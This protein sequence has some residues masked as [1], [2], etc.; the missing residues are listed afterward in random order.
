MSRSQIEKFITF[1]VFQITDMLAD[2]VVFSFGE[3]DGIFQLCATGEDWWEFLVE[4]NWLW[5]M[6][7]VER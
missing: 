4:K 2:E 3:A 5:K 7:L 6:K 1:H